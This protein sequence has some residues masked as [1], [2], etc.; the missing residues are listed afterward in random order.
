MGHKVTGADHDH[1]ESS[2][3]PVFH[4]FTDKEAAAAKPFSRR[5]SFG[6]KQGKIIRKYSGKIYICVFKPY[7]M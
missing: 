3:S 6:I 7:L 1:G 2:S 5:V 4:G